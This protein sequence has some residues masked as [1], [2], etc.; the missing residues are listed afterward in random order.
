[1]LEQVIVDQHLDFLHKHGWRTIRTHPIAIPGMVNT[2]EP[3][4]P[5][6]QVIRYMG[7]EAA[8]WKTITF[9]LECKSPDDKRGCRCKTVQDK[10]GRWKQ[11]Q[12]QVCRQKQWRERERA[13]GAVVIVS[14]DLEKFAKWYYGQFS[15]LHSDFS[16]ISKVPVAK[17]LDLIDHQ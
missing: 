8:P 17:Q 1:M 13:L 16:P 6:Y 4:M 2:G 14:D 15:Q 7:V 5:D 3:G 12:C 10:R 11:K 9:W